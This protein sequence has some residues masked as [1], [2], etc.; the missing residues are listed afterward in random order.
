MYN[1]ANRSCW[2]L[3]KNV[4]YVLTF[5]WEYSIIVL[6]RQGVSGSA[7]NGKRI[8]CI[9]SEKYGALN[10]IIRMK[11]EE[12]NENEKN[13]GRYSGSCNDGIRT[14]M[15]SSI[16][17]RRNWIICRKGIRKSWRQLYVTDFTE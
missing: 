2:K 7:R 9:S 11:K 12:N 10:A 1:F 16:C 15:E 17:S 3:Y 4:E 8:M 13:N 5:L 14:R 6:I